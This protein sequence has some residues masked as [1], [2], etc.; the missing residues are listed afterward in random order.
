MIRQTLIASAVVLSSTLAFVSTAQANPVEVLFG[1]T[2]TNSCT[3][4]NKVDGTLTA[5]TNSTLTSTGATPGTVTVTCS[6]PATLNVNAP[7]IKTAPVDYN[8]ATTVKSATV[9]GT[10]AASLNITVDD[11]LG[12]ATGAL[13]LGDTNLTVDMSADHGTVLPAGDYQFGVTMTATAL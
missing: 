1:G 9:A 4:S 13:V 2:V 3:F 6:G 10:G 8:D 7:A 11:T 12:V 5:P